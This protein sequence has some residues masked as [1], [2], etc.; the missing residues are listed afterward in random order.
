MMGMLSFAPSLKMTIIPPLL[1]TSL[2][3]IQKIEQT[4][5]L[6][7]FFYPYT[8]GP[9]PKIRKSD[10]DATSCIN[11]QINDTTKRNLPLG[12]VEHIFACC[13]FSQGDLKMQN[14]TE[15]K[16]R[17]LRNKIMHI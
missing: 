7:V 14:A 11:Y 3:F 1:M 15:E 13:S 17:I 2:G 6:C 16:C 4:F 10:I 9:M 12:L 8:A 5:L